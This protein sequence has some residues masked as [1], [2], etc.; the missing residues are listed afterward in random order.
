MKP[1]MEYI[2]L[3]ENSYLAKIY[4]SVLPLPMKIPMRLDCE[5]IHKNPTSENVKSVSKVFGNCE[6]VLHTTGR[7]CRFKR[8]QSSNILGGSEG[9]VEQHLKIVDDELIHSMSMLDKDITAVRT[10]A[11]KIKNSS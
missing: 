2:E 6:I 5:Y 9:P 8:Q 7:F 4:L 3:E 10:Y 1:D 11:R